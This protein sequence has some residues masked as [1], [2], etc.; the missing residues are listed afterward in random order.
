MVSAACAVSGLADSIQVSSLAASPDGALPTQA[1]T[2]VL[3]GT[4][5]SAT[6]GTSVIA[7]VRVTVGVIGV[8]VRVG[9]GV[10]VLVRVEVGTIGVRVGVL[11]LVGVGVFV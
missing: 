3:V 11:V 2:C 4:G 5:V 1:A 9:V 6:V 8:R 10:R 7:L